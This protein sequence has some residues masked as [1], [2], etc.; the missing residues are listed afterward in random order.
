MEGSARDLLEYRKETAGKRTKLALVLLSLLALTAV[1]RITQGEWAIPLARVA[2]L[3]SPFLSGEDLASPEALVVRS[4]RLPRFLAA[5]GT[6]GLLAVSG[7]V[8]QGLLAN[9]LAEPYTLGIASGA[10]FGGALG[11]FFGSFA[12]TPAAFAGALFA[13]WLVGVIAWRSG[14][15]GA[16]IVLAGIITNAVLSA[17]VT[18]LKALMGSLSGASP[19]SALMA[20]AGAAFVFVPAFVYGRQLDAVSLGEGRGELLGVDERKLRRTLLFFASIA[21]ALAVSCF[22]IIG[23]IQLPRR[24]SAALGGGRPRA[25]DGRASRRRHNGAHRRA[26]LLLDTRGK[27]ARGVSGAFVLDSVSCGYGGKGY[28]GKDILSG[29]SASVERGALTA[30]IGPNGS[31]KSTLLKLLG[32]VVG[33]R[34]SAELEGR[35]LRSMSRAEFGRAV[36]FVPQQTK[37]SSPFTVYEVIAMGRLP[38]CGLFSKLNAGDDAAVLDAAERAGVSH[39]LFRRASEL[40]GGEQQRVYIAVALAQDP[41]I[42]LLDEPTS[43]LDPSQSVRIFS[44]LRELAARGKT[45][46]VAAHDL[47]AAIPF[48]D[49]YI[50]LRGGALASQGAASE[51]DEKVL[52]PLYG[53]EFKK[54]TSEEGGRAWHPSAQGF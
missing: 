13:L 54:Y 37:I 40:S 1:W 17:G 7:V 20:W 50:A 35:E 34:G 14:G 41:D 11:F 4:V 16:Y 8:L 53:I 32:G 42:F 51:L 10:A 52:G 49:R 33:Y 22:G 27:E 25:E 6:G 19:A 43:A 45:V 15:G 9:P 39:L 24:R 12:V 18:F 30:L 26:V 3:I 44:I 29:F 5:A 47:N 38:Y 46:V 2:E 28:G 31:G 23:F 36:G 48:S 21:T